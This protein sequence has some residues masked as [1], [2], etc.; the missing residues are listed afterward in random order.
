MSENE[1]WNKFL[2]VLEEE[3][4]DFLKGK[5]PAKFTEDE[6][7]QGSACGEGGCE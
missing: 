5:S 3:S 4:E 2:E 1:K 6:I 7:R